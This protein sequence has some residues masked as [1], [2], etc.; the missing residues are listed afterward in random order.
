MWHSAVLTYLS[1]M[2]TG[3][4]PLDDA[5]YRSGESLDHALWFHRPVRMDD[6]VLLDL[7]PLSA[8]DG[9]GLYSGSIHD[10]SGRLAASLTQECLFRLSP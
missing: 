6:W 1:D 5:E 10:Q 3:I 2:S 8:S 4:S 9:G 7:V